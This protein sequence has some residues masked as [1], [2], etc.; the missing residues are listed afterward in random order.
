MKF[1]TEHKKVIGEVIH[2]IST[3]KDDTSKI[4]LDSSGLTIQSVTV[5]KAAAKFETADEKLNIT[6]SAPKSGTRLDV[7]IHYE[8]VPTKGL[9]FILPD[10][11]Y[12]QRPI[13]IWSQGE[14]QDIHYFIPTYDYPNDRLTTETVLTVPAAW[15]T[16]AN[17]KLISVSNAADN[18]RTWTWKESQLSSTYLITV[19]AGE[20]DEV[21][22]SYGKL[23]V[24]YY[25]P[26]GRGDRLKVNYGRTPAMIE[27]FNKKIRLRLS[28]GKIRAGHGR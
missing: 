4:S 13:Q 25:A 28:L 11:D 1:D 7:D 17:G 14:S 24:P 10:K 20:F 16:I 27:L 12:P 15:Q 22:D 19:V 23:P 2:T 3:L 6:V 8:G 18:M 5:N 9:Y 26:K 21:K